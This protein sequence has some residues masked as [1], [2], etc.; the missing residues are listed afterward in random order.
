MARAT[1]FRIGKVRGDLRGKVWYLTYLENGRRLRPRVGSDRDAA[2]Q[3]AAQINAQL[4]VSAPTA[5]SFESI[6][7][8]ELQRRWLE[9]HEQ[10]LR[11]SVHQFIR[12]GGIGQRLSISSIFWLSNTLL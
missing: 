2:R 3:M 9:H 6:R 10:I 11:S 1:S 12:F 7:I 5:F 4:E 8:D